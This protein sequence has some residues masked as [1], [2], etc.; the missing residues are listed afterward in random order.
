MGLHIVITIH[1]VIPFFKRKFDKI[2]LKKIYNAADKIVVHTKHSLDELVTSGIDDAKIVIIPHSH[3]IMGN[4]DT[5]M[6][7]DARIALDLPI[8]LKYLLFFG[9]IKKVKGLQFLIE[10][11]CTLCQSRRDLGL[12]IAGK[13]WHDDFS[14]YEGK[15]IPEADELVFRH[16]RFIP[17][18]EVPLFF[19]AADIVVLPYTEIYQ[20]GVLH[21]AFEY[22][23]PVIA[24]DI[25]GFKETIINMQNGV[26]VT[27]SDADSLIKAIRI[28]IDDAQLQ[29]KI[30]AEAYD[31][32]HRNFSLDNK[33]K[34]LIQ[35]YNALLINSR[36]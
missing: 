30:A 10:V 14:F 23:R 9:Q 24:S 5:I 12:I 31:Y 4:T 16:I 3:Y 33:A 13:P 11:F 28:L 34:L 17:E 26:L 15:I 19:Q 35:T 20:S 22:K 25:G 36:G 27:P 21:L 8:D 32:L 29:Q 2:Y 7:K 18:K 1:D 6:Q